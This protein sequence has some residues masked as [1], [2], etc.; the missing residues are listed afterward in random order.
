MF[1]SKN[2]CHVAS[3]NR[4]TVKVGVFVYRTTDDLDTVTVSG[5]FNE[6]IIDINL[7]DLIIHEQIDVADNTKVKRNLL[8]VTER[9]LENVGTTLVKSDWE[10]E[11]DENVQQL[12]DD[13]EQIQEDIEDIQDKDVEQDER[14]TAIETGAAYKATDFKTPITNNNK[15]ITE[16]EETTLNNKIDLAANSGRMITEKGV[17]YAKMYAQTVAPSAEDGTNYADFSQLD[18]EGNHIIVLYNRVNGAWVQDQTILP[19]ADYD[20]YVPITSKIWDIV[21]QSGQQGG[22][23]LWNHQSKSF[24]PYPQIISFEN[25]ALTGNSTVQMPVTPTGDSIVNVDYVA[26]HSGTG[27]NVGDIFFTS[28]TDTELNGAVECNGSTYNGSDF[29]GSQSPIALMNAGKIPYVSLAVYA[30]TITNQGWCDKFGWD[31]GSATTFRVP[32]LNAYIWQKL[33]AIIKGSVGTSSV[34]D[35]GKYFVAQTTT[36]GQQTN[37]GGGGYTVNVSNDQTIPG[38]SADATNIVSDQR[39]M[40]QLATSSTDEAVETCTGV[41]A[42]V[43]DLKNL[44]NITSAGIETAVGWGMPDYANGVILSNLDTYQNFNEDGFLLI[45]GSGNG[46]WND[47][48]V[49][50][51]LNGTTNAYQ[52]TTANQY[53][54]SIIIPLPKGIYIKRTNSYVNGLVFFPCKK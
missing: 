42:D 6:K 35:N 19:P 52:I 26:T 36:F 1:K 38:A 9:T 45:R 50:I 29:V 34:S 11:I 23:I 47:I 37:P 39:V 54:V 17:W 32:T 25:A 30:S 28:R 7:H 53:T 43:A 5:Y 15:G 40:V 14:L 4:N 51:S 16:T 48:G 10:E 41:L 18:G 27:R 31:G 21:E 33:Q 2:F 3:N 24:T 13:V 44:S 8:C 49:S 22:R 46:S 12:L 20:G